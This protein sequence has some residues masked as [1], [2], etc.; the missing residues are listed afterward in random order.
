MSNEKLQ[1]IKDQV[2]RENGYNNFDE[3]KRLKTATAY[4]AWCTHYM[5]EIAIRYAQSQEPVLR[6]PDAKDLAQI[7]EEYAYDNGYNC[8]ADFELNASIKSLKKSIDSIAN[9]YFAESSRFSPPPNNELVEAAQNLLKLMPLF[10][11]KTT[12]NAFEEFETALLKFKE[13]GK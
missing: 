7:K 2:A 1:A 4:F 12:I 13:N 10:A 11:D 6:E 5:D 9:F 3:L 8:W